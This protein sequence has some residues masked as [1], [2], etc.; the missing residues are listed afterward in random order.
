MKKLLAATLIGGLLTA[1]AHLEPTSLAQ[2][3][4]VAT[5]DGPMPCGVTVAENGRIFINYPHWGDNPPFTVGELKNGRVFAYPNAAVNRGDPARAAETLISVQSVVADGANRLWILDTG[6]PNFSKPIPG[7]AKLVAVD[8]ATNQIVRSILL[9]PDVLRPNSYV[10]DMRFDLRQGKAGVAYITD[11]SAG[12]IIVVDLASEHALRRLSGH[13]SVSPDPD[14]VPKIEGTV[15]MNR[16]ADGPSTPFQVASDG[17]AISPDG[18]LLYY[19]PLSSRH[20]YSVPTAL[21]R[22]VKVSDDT[23]AAAVRDLGLKGAS[24][25]LAEDAQGRIYGGDYEN[26]AIRQYTEGHWQTLA[27]DPRILWPDTLSIGTDGY[28]YFTANQLHRQA[29]FHNGVDQR[30]RPY[31]LLRIHVGSGP[32]ILRR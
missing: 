11:S 26:N 23:I 1:C 25:G 2:V 13:A 14:F 32:V 24:D 30:Q 27:Q 20:L 21:L 10:N 12:G 9:G 4:R 16:P 18:A 28:L 5:F 7:G 17:I 29:G 22:D 31:E 6:A 8:M 19:S 3:E 15:L